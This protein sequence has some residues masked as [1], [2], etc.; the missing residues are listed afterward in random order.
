M[1]CL[2]LR[3]KMIP[4]NTIIGSKA[5]HITYGICTITKIF[6]VDRVSCI[7]DENQVILRTYRKFL[8]LIEV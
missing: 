8:T 6:D 7:I 1:K 3:N 5:Y 4:K 2:K